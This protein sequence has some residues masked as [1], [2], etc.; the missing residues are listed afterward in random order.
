MN[1]IEFNELVE[2][3]VELLDITNKYCIA[4]YGEKK[5]IFNYFQVNYIKI[6][7]NHRNFFC[8]KPIK[9]KKELIECWSLYCVISLKDARKL[10]NHF[11]KI[12]L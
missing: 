2:S 10:V 6:S 3:I 12:N 5:T 9:N 7:K 1:Q 8:H 4:P 11:L